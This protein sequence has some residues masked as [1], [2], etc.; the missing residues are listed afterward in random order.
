MLGDM[1]IN[2]VSAKEM[3]ANSGKYLS[4]IKGIVQL[5][6]SIHDKNDVKAITEEI[7]HILGM[8]AVMFKEMYHHF[9]R[10]DAEKTWRELL[11]HAELI[12]DEMSESYQRH[13]VIYD[14]IYDLLC[15]L[16]PQRL[17]FVIRVASAI[18]AF[19]WPHRERIAKWIA[20]NWKEALGTAA[21]FA[22]L[23]LLGGAAY[24]GYKALTADNRRNNRRN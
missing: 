6:G 10:D 9:R 13:Q 17:Q 1:Q 23:A 14:Q 24:L 11:R 8:M 2:G 16:L 3:F 22:G 20:H 19:A 5:L 12:H 21:V 18:A 4:V 15:T 7:A